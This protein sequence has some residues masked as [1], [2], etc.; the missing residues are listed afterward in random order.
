VL[1]LTHLAL[2]QLRADMAESGLTLKMGYTELPY[3][4]RESGLKY[5]VFTIKYFVIY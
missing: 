5:F 2:S 4:V 3:F 1:K